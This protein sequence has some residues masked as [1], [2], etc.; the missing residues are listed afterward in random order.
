MVSPPS[1][2][3]PPLCFDPALFPRDHPLHASSFEPEISD[4]WSRGGPSP[5]PS[6][7][8]AAP[9]A[10][11]LFNELLTLS[12]ATPCDEKQLMVV[13]AAET[14]F[15]ST[16]SS[17]V[18]P[19]LA[20]VAKQKSLLTPY[21][22]LYADKR[23]CARA[24]LACFF[25]PLSHC[26][27]E[28]IARDADAKKKGRGRRRSRA[29]A[30]SDTAGEPVH[31]GAFLSRFEL[32]AP[33]PLRINRPRATFFSSRISHKASGLR[34]LPERFRADGWFAS[35]AATYSFLLRPSAELGA[36]LA[37]A[38]ASL[39]WPADG[40]VL[41][42]HV[43]MGDACA[44]SEMARTSRRCDALEAYAPHVERLAARYGVRHVF[45]ATDSE[46]VVGAAR[47]RFAR[48]G[49]ALL[50]QKNV[51]VRARGDA[52]GGGGLID[53]LLRNGKV[54]GYAEGWAAALDLLLLGESAA[55]VG[56]FTS[57]LDRIAYAL[58]SARGG[59][60][61]PYVSLDAA[62]CFDFGVRG[63]GVGLNGTRFQC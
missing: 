15:G 41:G 23:R 17:L 52:A 20:S 2:A 46:A 4:G 26:D 25:R 58:M 63:S 40:K 53:N 35:V 59:C 19:L 45:L 34:A 54:D 61:R 27:E 42:L 44:A 30:P 18:K 60:L 7:R 57:N 9:R 5:D 16:L 50:Y 51:S 21:L 43:R 38:K 32:A 11:A 6:L 28:P 24:D 62:W 31:G 49:L 22:L 13:D 33:S 47:R 3:A 14:G 55:L 48:T 8:R 39:G 12:T 37:A 56:K 29:A 36:A 1:T 10:S